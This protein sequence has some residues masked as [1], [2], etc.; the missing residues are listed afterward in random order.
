MWVR[1]T[2]EFRWAPPELNNTWSQVFQPST[3]N[4]TTACANAAIAAGKAVK[5]K[6]PT[7]GETCVAQGS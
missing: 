7:K 2:D 3:L 5:V 1:F 4:V 6:R